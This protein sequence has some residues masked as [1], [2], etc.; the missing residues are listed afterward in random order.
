MIVQVVFLRRLSTVSSCGFFAYSFP[1][2]LQ[3]MGKQ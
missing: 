2:R 1:G 3:P